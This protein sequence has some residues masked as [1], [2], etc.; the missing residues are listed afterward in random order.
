M[1]II[2][3]PAAVGGGAVDIDTA[4]ESFGNAAAKGTQI[5]SGAAHT[6]GAWTQLVASGV[7][8]AV[9]NH[10]TGFTITACEAGSST[11]RGLMDIGVGDGD[12]GT[13]VLIPNIS[14]MVGTVGVFSIAF[15]GLNLAAGQ[16][17]WARWQ[18]QGSGATI[19][20]RGEGEI[21]TPAHPPGFA[22][23]EL[24][25]GGTANSVPNSVDLAFVAAPDTGWTTV[26]ALP[27]DAGAF[28]VNLGLRANAGTSFSP[29]RAVLRLGY[30]G[31]GAGDAVKVHDSPV[32]VSGSGPY[33]RSLVARTIRKA[34]PA[35]TRIACE[36]YAGAAG[37]VAAPQVWALRAA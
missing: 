20:V 2:S 17:L 1:R 3:P 7:D 23:C 33:F 21:R 29:Q 31:V 12:G 11:T 26:A 32:E 8:G 27:H 24:L 30:G 16:K 35:G 34:L 14:V 13:T 36:V 10:L 19:W 9:G 22:I 18:S 4:Y 37:D 5:V 15:D 25:A 28:V 6:K